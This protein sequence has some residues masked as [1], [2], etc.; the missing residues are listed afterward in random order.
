M[1]SSVT[2]DPYEA[3]RHAS[4][5][6]FALSY[7]LAI[8]GTQVLYATA[9]WDIY[10]RTKDPLAVGLI[11]LIGAIPV[12]VLALPAGHV[13]DRFSRKQVL[14]VTQ[15][16]L[17]II[18]LTLAILRMGNHDGVSLSVEFLL[19]GANS[20]AL[21]FARPARSS[22]LPNL[23]PRSA[24]TNAF[25]WISSLFE[26]ASWV[27]PA[28][29]GVLIQLSVSWSYLVAGLCLLG[30]LVTTLFLPADRPSEPKPHESGWRELSAGLRFVFST[31]LLLAAMTLDLFAVLFGGATYLL[32]IFA[33]RLHVGPVGYGLLRAAPALGAF[34]VA[35][36]QAHRS[37]YRRAGQTLLLSVA[38]FGLAT[39]VFGLSTS[40]WLSL[41]MLAIIGGSDNISVV[42]RQTLVQTLTPDSMRGRVSAVNQVFIGA[43]NELGGLESG[44]TAKL[45]GLVISVVGGGIGTLLVVCGVAGYWPQLRR[46]GSLKELQSLVETPADSTGSALAPTDPEPFQNAT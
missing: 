3:F 45:F 44:V 14:L 19:L 32:P 22:I 27:G 20:V 46:L 42:I 12:I 31:P 13:V 33:E 28:L 35:V 6:L 39:I 25:A 40:F 10:E 36:I 4:F 24:Y 8:I 1:E 18:P 30:C 38:V 41:I 37:P 26:T 11:G 34:V 7:G 5:R 17:T 16:P 29:S 23:I 43:S 21:T 2:H 9:Q 15:A